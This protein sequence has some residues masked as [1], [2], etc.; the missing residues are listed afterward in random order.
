MSTSR[1]TK[2]EV[3]TGRMLVEETRN[4][5]LKSKAENSE[6]W[7]DPSRSKWAR[8]RFGPTLTE[9][10]G[11]THASGDPFNEHRCHICGEIPD[12][13]AFFIRITP[14]DYGEGAYEMN[15]C[16]KCAS[17]LESLLWKQKN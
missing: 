1:L 16:K 11:V 3:L 14:P 15:I 9:L 8:I 13:D 7:T 2:I 4:S 6:W 12:V 17:M 10:E 5:Y